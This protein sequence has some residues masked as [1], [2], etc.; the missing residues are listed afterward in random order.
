MKKKILIISTVLLVIIAIVVT[1]YNPNREYKLYYKVNLGYIEESKKDELNNTYKDLSC[2]KD[3]IVTVDDIKYIP[4][5]GTIL[6]GNYKPGSIVN[7]SYFKYKDYLGD[8]LMDYKYQV[9]WLYTNDLGEDINKLEFKYKDEEDTQVFV[10]HAEYNLKEGTEEELYKAY[11]KNHTNA[12]NT[13]L[14]NIIETCIEEYPKYIGRVT[15]DVNSFIMP[16]H[17]VYL[18]YTEGD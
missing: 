9:K 7:V 15:K 17:D 2:N 4:C 10:K 16:K 14:V 12:Y 1:I 5:T 8:N 6:A 13:S 3:N 11:S 18:V